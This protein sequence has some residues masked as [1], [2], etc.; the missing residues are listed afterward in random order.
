MQDCDLIE[1]ARGFRENLLNFFRRQ[2]V[3]ESDLDDHLQETYVRLWKYRDEYRP[4]AKLSTFLF[5]LA[6]QVLID[7][8]RRRTNRS[9]REERWQEE[10]P[11]WVSPQPCLRGDVE[12][13]MSRLSPPLRETVELAL[14]Q[15]LPYKEI[16]RILDIPV[17][18]VKSRVSNAIKKL[19]ELFDDS[20][21]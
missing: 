2:G 18:T 1:R 10:R 3:I 13:A 6:R 11:V 14:F 17:G 5:I 7:C 16:S 19:K 4:S 8:Y 15:D 20:R 12:W 9:R 21:S